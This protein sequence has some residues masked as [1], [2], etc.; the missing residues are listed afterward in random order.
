MPSYLLRSVLLLLLAAN[1]PSST[2]A[3]PAQNAQSSV[4]ITQ[5]DLFS[6]KG[7]DSGQVTFLGFRLGMRRNEAFR[8]AQNRELTMDD[9]SGQG[10]LKAATCHLLHS[11]GYIGLSFSFGIQDT[12]QRI[13]IEMPSSYASK[14]QREAWLAA[15]IPGKTGELFEK[16]SDN[17]RARLLGVADAS[18]FDAPTTGRSP[19]SL[20]SAKQEYQ[21]YSK[22]LILH[23]RLRATKPSRM[24][25]RPQVAADF[26]FPE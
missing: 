13:R 26:L 15:K 22:G 5:V 18:W 6:L 23:V 17:M 9:D 7:W 16:Y 10:C 3:G 14:E 12:I 20:Q 4:E 19:F 11:G 1:F 8:N 24:L 2:G 25:Q 21:Y